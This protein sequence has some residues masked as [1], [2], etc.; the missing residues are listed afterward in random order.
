LNFKRPANDIF[1]KTYARD[2]EGHL[3]TPRENILKQIKDTFAL[4]F[5]E[6]LTAD[7]SKYLTRPLTASERAR[8]GVASLA[9]LQ[10]ALDN[11]NLKMMYIDEFALTF[12]KYNSFVLNLNEAE[13]K[14]TYAVYVASR[15]DGFGEGDIAGVIDADLTTNLSGFMGSYSDRVWKPEEEE[16][17]KKMR[18]LFVQKIQDALGASDEF[19]PLA[20]RT[21]NNNDRLKSLLE[22]DGIITPE[23]YVV[24]SPNQP[25]G[26]EIPP[27]TRFYLTRPDVKIRLT[28]WSWICLARLMAL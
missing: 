9:D 3:I 10:T 6:R 24:V 7:E 25:F 13:F 21:G 23:L 8:L 18:I 17:A 22:L 14:F 16:D 5:K 19:A 20:P 11:N 26:D 4:S 2:V 12:V 28:P 1:Y 27:F 15:A